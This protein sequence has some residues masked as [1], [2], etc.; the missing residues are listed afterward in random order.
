MTSSRISQCFPSTPLRDLQLHSQAPFRSLRHVLRFYAH[1][2]RTRVCKWSILTARIGNFFNPI[3][4]ALKGFFK[5]L[6]FVTRLGSLAIGMSHAKV[7][8]EG[9]EPQECKRNAGRSKPPILYIPE[10]DDLQEAVE[11]SANTL[12]LLLPHKVS[13]MSLSG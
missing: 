9:L 3:N 11:S 6:F 4:C 7:A 10:K 13:C 2:S 12:K 5:S 8:P 1:K